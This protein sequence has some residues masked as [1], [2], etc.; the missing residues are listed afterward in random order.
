[1]TMDF[2]SAIDKAIQEFGV[3]I[4]L[5]RSRL[6]NVINDYQSFKESPNFRGVIIDLIDSG[7][8]DRL[9]S[10]NI[11]RSRF[12]RSIRSSKL[13]ENKTNRAEVISI[14]ESVLNQRLESNTAQVQINRN[15]RLVSQQTPA[16]PS[17][18]TNVISV[19][20]AILSYLG[21]MAGIVLYFIDY[22]EYSIPCVA[23]SIVV[24]VLYYWLYRLRFVTKES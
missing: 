21:I 19:I 8:M 17:V 10:D 2:R 16:S 5:D 14:I 13:H 23:F 24:I 11:L 9:C 7:E 1:M 6:V 18:L 4:L 12:R 3:D 15:Q 22:D 20:L